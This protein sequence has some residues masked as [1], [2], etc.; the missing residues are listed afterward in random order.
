[1]EWEYH[2]KFLLQLMS[3]IYNSIVIQWTK[4]CRY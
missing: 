2:V 1:M 3:L 4:C